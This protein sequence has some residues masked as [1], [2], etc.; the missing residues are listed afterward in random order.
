MSPWKPR[1]RRRNLPKKKN[2]RREQNINARAEF[3]KL[4]LGK[5]LEQGGDSGDICIP[6]CTFL[7]SDSFE[8]LINLPPVKKKN[9]FILVPLLLPAM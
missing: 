1:E 4:L 9:T 8:S 5:L 3:K 2:T 7:F 6:A